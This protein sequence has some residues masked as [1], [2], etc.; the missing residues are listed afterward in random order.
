MSDVLLGALSAAWLGILTAISPCPMAT[1][2]AAIAFVGRRVESPMKALGAGL[3]YAAGR[4]LTYVALGALLAESLLSAPYLS[5]F[6]QKYMNKLLGP[7][8]ILVGMVLLE[9]I[10]INV[11]GLS[12]SGK[13]QKRVEAMGWAGALLLGVAFALSFCPVSA[14]LFFG[15][16]VPL[17]LKFEAGVLMSAAYG[18]ATALPVLAFA[19]LIAFGAERLGRAYDALTLV[20]RWLRRGTGGIFIAVGVYYAM[21]HIFGVL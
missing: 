21:V 11:A 1:N 16:L 2:I 3:L 14:A 10:Q 18:V 8:L 7:I 15:S 20:E 6:L 17:A 19:V 4:M 5:H 9:L 13:M 12:A